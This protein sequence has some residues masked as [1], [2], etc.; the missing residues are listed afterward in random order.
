MSVTSK[1]LMDQL[2]LVMRLLTQNTQL[3][4]LTL[5][6][7]TPHL[8]MTK[9][10]VRKLCIMRTQ[11]S[12]I[13]INWRISKLHLLHL[14][15]SQQV[16]RMHHHHSQLDRLLSM[17]SAPHQSNHRKMRTLTGVTLKKNQNSQK[18]SLQLQNPW[19]LRSKRT[20]QQTKPLQSQQRTQNPYTH[21][22]QLF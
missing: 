18:Q 4:S 8:M 13:L 10:A 3:M 20:I 1:S 15:K 16:R 7:K 12:T 6:M 17:W 14:M 19:N 9:E 21:Q 5:P 2:V 11:M 22:H